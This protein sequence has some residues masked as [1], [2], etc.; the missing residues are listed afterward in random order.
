[1]MIPRA[2]A[3]YIILALLLI[4]SCNAMPV[5]NVVNPSGGGC[6]TYIT[7]N[8]TG[9][10]HVN[11]TFTG[12]EGT[13]ALVTN[14]NTPQ[15][16][17]L[18]FTI[19][20]GNTGLTGGNG[21]NSTI[22]VNATFTGAAGTSA[23]VINIGDN[24][25]ARFDFTI[26]TGEMNQTPNMTSSFVGSQW[27]DHNIASSDIA[28]YL[29]FNRTIPAST[30]GSSSAT[31]PSAGTEYLIKAF[32]TEARDPSILTLPA[33][34]R[35]WHTYAKVSSTAGGDSRI[36]IRLYKRDILNVE[37][38]M[39]NLTTG[40]L[41]IAISDDATTVTVPSDIPMALTDRF[42]AKYYAIT[43]SA[44]NPTITLYYDGT[45]HVSK[46]SSPINQGIAGEKGD[47]GDPGMNATVAVNATF[48]LPSGS[49]ATVA[50][51]GNETA[52]SLDFG[53]PTGATPSIGG[54]ATEI[55]YNADGA[56]MGAPCMTFDN[57]TGVFTA[58]YISGDGTAITNVTATGNSV[59]FQVR[60]GAGV[61]LSKAQ[62]AYVYGGSTGIPTV[63]KAVN[64][65]SAKA[66][67]V[68]IML[69]NT[70]ANAV[71]Y[72][73]RNGVLSNVD[74]RSSNTAINPMAKRGTPG[75]YCS[76]L[77]LPGV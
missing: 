74:T 55:L 76:Y 22:D 59:Q 72:V 10:L 54:N 51:V 58:C 18:D 5:V 47:K 67:V 36:V 46:A 35:I 33:G 15:D 43:D 31:A 39:Y 12:A 21:T 53:I 61:A 73:I 64:T 34:D 57:A 75:I 45:A 29:R 50:N 30:E 42:V 63:A 71:G 7:Y 68:G 23:S 37:T 16:P 20:R 41:G 56:I 69:A 17:Y 11:Y 25:T 52:A 9:E 3:I 77:G 40:A 38:E 70:N 26:P 24:V 4:T 2:F 44:S 48:T 14:I 13:D 27:Y 66:R 19:P 28:G 32:A 62:A 65:D 1:M 6:V 60:E 8:V 49:D